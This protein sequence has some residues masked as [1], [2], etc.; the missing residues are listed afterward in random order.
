ML[1]YNRY[2]VIQGRCFV[3]SA[4][5]LAMEKTGV[6]DRGKLTEAQKEEIAEIRSKANARMAEEEIMFQKKTAGMPA[7]DAKTEIEAEYANTVR[8]IREQMESDIEKARSNG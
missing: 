6:G 8:K 2:Q 7:G 5:E 4:I 3:K 1:N